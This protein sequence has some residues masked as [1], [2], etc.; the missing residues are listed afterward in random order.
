MKFR[1]I[2]QHLGDR[3]Y[4]P[5]DEREATEGDVAH[6]VRAG[7]LEPLSAKAE[8][9]PNNKAEKGAPANKADK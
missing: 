4:W 2:R 9:K 6:L 3:M 8:P 1:V 7:V 5:G